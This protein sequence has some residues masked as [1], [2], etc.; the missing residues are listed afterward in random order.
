M[1]HAHNQF[2]MT[3]PK[4]H[5]H[6]LTQL[7]LK[8]GLKSYGK[9][10]D[11]AILKEL[12]QPHVQEVLMHKQQNKLMYKERKRALSYLMFLKDKRDGTITT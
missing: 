4:T 10:G 1:T 5:P 8:D 12:N 6:L 7:N 11:K 3:Q 2:T 9:K